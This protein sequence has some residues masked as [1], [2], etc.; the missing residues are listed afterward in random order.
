MESNTLFTKQKN[1]LRL[2]VSAHKKEAQLLKEQ[3][4]ILMR[5]SSKTLPEAYQERL[6]HLKE[7]EIALQQELSDLMS[8]FKEKQMH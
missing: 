6:G 7:Q 4:R 2:K 8:V 1:E 3:I 5:G